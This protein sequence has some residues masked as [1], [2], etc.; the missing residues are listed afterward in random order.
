VGFY[1]ILWV[2]L[3]LGVVGCFL[4]GVLGAVNAAMDEWCERTCRRW[5]CILTDSA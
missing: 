2:T 3:W 5:R 4:F 1:I